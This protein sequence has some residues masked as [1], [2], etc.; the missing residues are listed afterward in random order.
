MS[1][2]QSVIESIKAQF[3][4]VVQDVVEFRGEY[5]LVIEPAKIAEVARFCRDADGLEFTILSDIGGIDYYPDEPRFAVSYVLFSLSQNLTIRLKVYLQEDSPR[6]PTL[7]DVYSSAGWPERE[8]Y[9]MFGVA[10]EGHPDPRR[11]L[12]P[13]DWTGHPL[14]KDYPLGYEEVQFSFNYDRVKDQKPSPR[15]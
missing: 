5:T 1:D 14:R 10:F 9:D 7:T 4:D 11:I 6:V 13:F 3:P 8:V 12:M 2:Y 15:E